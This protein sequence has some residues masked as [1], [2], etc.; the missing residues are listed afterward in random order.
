MK[1]FALN[2]LVAVRTLI[3][4]Y[5]QHQLDY[6]PDVIG[7]VVRNPR[8]D[9]F[10]H[11]FIQMVHITA[12]EGWLKSKHLVDDAAK[13]PDIRLVTVGLI[14]PHLGG[15]VVRSAR[16]RVVKPVLVGHFA[17]VHVAEFRLVKVPAFHLCRILVLE[18]KNVGR[19]DVPMHDAQFV[20][21]PQSIDRLN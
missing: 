21:G 11:A 9:T 10:A 2:E 12:T 14:L 13:G 18:H 15:G 3:R 20:H 4:I 1:H 6:R 7:V 19:L 5:A 16:L 17:H 8:E